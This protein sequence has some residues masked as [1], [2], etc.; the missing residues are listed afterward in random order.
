MLGQDIA[1]TLCNMICVACVAMCCS[2]LQFVAECCSVL[3]CVAMLRQD[4]AKT[5]CKTI[6]VAAWCSVVQRAAVC[7]SVLQRVAKALV[8]N[9]PTNFLG[10]KI[11]ATNSIV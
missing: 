3:Q 1:K 11:S 10:I 8:Q 2:V 4:T 5:L 6:C 9:R 7:C